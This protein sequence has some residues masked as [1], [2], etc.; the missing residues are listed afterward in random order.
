VYDNLIG[1]VRAVDPDQ[2]LILEPIYG[3][4]DPREADLGRISAPNR[5]NLIWSVR[6]YYAGDAG[7]GYTST[8]RTTGTQLWSGLDPPG[9]GDVG[10][11]VV[12]EANGQLHGF[13][14]DLD[15]PPEATTGAELVDVAVTS[16]QCGVWALHADGLVTS[17]GRASALA[18]A[19]AL[20]SLR[21]DEHFV[22][23]TP[24]PT[25]AGLWLFTNHG[26]VV[27]VGDAT[28]Q[29]GAGGATD[30]LGFDLQ[31][32]IIDSTATPDGTG[33]LMLGTDGGVFVFADEPFL[34]SL[35]ASP[36]DTPVVAVG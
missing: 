17:R 31:G 12:G 18:G 4:S 21:P 33:Y 11:Y 13:G 20:V 10:G 26:R 1:Q 2:I 28:L 36:P 24:T 27:T 8:G 15:S 14:L 29:R 23:L 16:D 7:V 3:N 6:G 35:G 34:G 32:S 25:D 30:L 22:A 5:T 9:C 19:A